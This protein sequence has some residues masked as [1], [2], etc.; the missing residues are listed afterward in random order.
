MRSD[1]DPLAKIRHLLT[2]PPVD[3]REIAMELGINIWQSTSLPDGIAGK[4]TTDPKHKPGRSGFAI[5]IRKGDLLPVKRFTI[6]HEFG[7]YLLHRTLLENGE[8]VDRE[9]P[10]GKELYRSN[11]ST[12]KEQL[13]NKVASDILMPWSLL[14]PLISERRSTLQGLFQVSRTMLDI[15]LDSHTGRR[16]KRG[17]PANPALEAE[18]KTLVE[19]WHK[20]T[21]HVS[22]VRKRIEHPA[23]RRIIEIGSNVLPMLFRELNE[24][25]SHWLVALHAITHEDPAPEGSTFREAVGAWLAWGRDRGYLN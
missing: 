19:K 5:V 13:A 24:R 10:Q 16:L 11:L 1:E 17:A 20:D 22:S 9:E 3:L 4:L 12:S 8:I 21:Q 23:Y 2:G 18:F 14:A 25:P 7:H 15:R 6:A